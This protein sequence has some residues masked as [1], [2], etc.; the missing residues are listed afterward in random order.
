MWQSNEPNEWHLF[1]NANSWAA[2]GPIV[3]GSGRNLFGLDTR[4]IV[5][6]FIREHVS[7]QDILEVNG[8][9]MTR[10]DILAHDRSDGDM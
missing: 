5:I 1:Y 3:C 2:I 7:E 4:Q 6:D 9:Q 10:A 8:I